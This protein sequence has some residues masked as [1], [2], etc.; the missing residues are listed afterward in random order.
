[1]SLILC[2]ECGTK[3]SDRAVTCP[4]CGF[5][6]KKASIPISK[7]DVYTPVPVFK[8]E[9][10]KWDPN[11]EALTEIPIDDNR[12]L[13]EFFGKW[14]NI[15]MAMPAL[16]QVIQAMAKKDKVL[17]ADLDRYVAKLVEKGIYRFMYDKNGDILP[18]IRDADKIVKQIRLKE[19]KLSPQLSQS[20]T[21]LTMQVQMA[22]IL[23]EIEYV[24]DA[25]R[26]IHKELQNDRIAM[27]E[28]AWD[29]LRQ[30][31]QIQDSRLRE[32]AILSV[33]GT[34]T[35]AKRILMRNF[36]D[37]RILLEDNARKPL[38]KMVFE[39]NGKRKDISVRAEDAFQ[40]LISITNCVQV[41]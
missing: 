24:E 9:I 31:R 5:R 7:Q 34:A 26:N 11:R 13:F 16:A 40:E 35:E 15:E 3:I 22:Q 12:Q 38:R 23:D 41:E 2:P 30:A 10:E 8:C 28:S 17:V 14:K 4:Y 29:K 21:N 27:A 1:M 18:I 25:I 36:A 6:S 32:V 39:T 20:L 19:V 37:N 33:I